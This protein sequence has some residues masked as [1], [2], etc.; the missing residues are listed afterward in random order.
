MYNSAC[1]ADRVSVAVKSSSIVY[2]WVHAESRIASY[3]VTT[4]RVRL[5]PSPI[6][7]DQ[8]SQTNPSL[9]S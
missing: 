3:A 5:E 6:N 4:E 2:R 9:G 1:K 8:R 7:W